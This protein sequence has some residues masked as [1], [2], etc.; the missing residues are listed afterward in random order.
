MPDSTVSISSGHWKAEIAP[1]CGANPV[2]VQ[3]DGQDILIPQTAAAGDPFLIGSPLLLPANR[4]AGGRFTFQGAA[5]TLPVNDSFHCANLHGSL[6]RQCFQ[7]TG[8]SPDGVSLRFENRGAVYP[9]AFTICVRYCISENSFV[10]EYTIENPA[11]VPMPLTFG[12]HTTFRDAG[13]FRVPLAACQEK[14]C[15]HIPTGRYIP[16]S[17]QERSYCDGIC[18]TGIPISGFYL[19]AGDTAQI[20]RR[21]RYRAEGFDHWILYNGGGAGGFLCVEPQLGGVN[22]LN[23]EENC[24]IIPPG[25]VLRLKTQLSVCE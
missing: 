4:T 5:Y 19:A 18:P 3:Y 21:I 8:R 1:A 9:F 20:G 11:A 7:V 6:C 2:C 25:G 15:R 14:D 12:L 16:L 24:P 22:A 23:D 13:W 17:P 10:S